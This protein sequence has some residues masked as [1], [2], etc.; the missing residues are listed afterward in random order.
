L[1]DVQEFIKRYSTFEKL[2]NNNYPHTFKRFWLYKLEVENEDNHILDIENRAKTVTQLG[3]ILKLWKWHE[4][5]D[6][7][8]CYKRMERSLEKISDSYDRIRNFNLTEFDKIPENDLRRIWIEFGKIKD[9]D[10]KSNF[11]GEIVETITKP[12]MFLWGQTPAFDSI[13]RTKMPLRNCPGFTNQRWEFRLWLRV[14]KELQQILIN[15]SDIVD[16]F[17]K[18]FKEKYGTTIIG[19]YGQF[20][21]LYYWTENRLDTLIA[22]NAGTHLKNKP[23]LSFEEEKKKEDYHYLVS[24]L[25][26]LRSAEKITASE[27]RNIERNWRNQP[28]NNDLLLQDLERKIDLPIKKNKA[29]KSKSSI[30]YSRKKTRL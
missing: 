27:R 20:F 17:R 12:L 24:L 14:M 9:E 10:N 23:N 15:N 28:N 3:H 4:P 11:I 13:V 22:T 29:K 6:F 5:Y 1:I 2:D 8:H 30:P 25:N 7:N 19:P 21:D 16:V 18:K 26:Q